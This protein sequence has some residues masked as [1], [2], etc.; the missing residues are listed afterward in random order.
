MR[1][2]VTCRRRIS[3]RCWRSSWAPAAS[4][5]GTTFASAARRA[6]TAE[7]LAQAGST[8]GFEVEVVPPVTLDGER[9]SSSGVR[10]ALAARGLRAR[11]ALARTALF[12]VRARGGGPAPGAGS[13]VPD[14]EPAAQAPARPGGRHFCGARARHCRRAARRGGEPRH[15]PHGGGTEALLEAHVFDFQGD[16]YGR[17]IEVEFVAK[18]RDEEHFAD[19]RRADRA[20]ACGMPPRRAAS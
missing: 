17:E 18:L 20:D 13:R 6:A 19:A 2:C 9:V 4:W 5:S 7:V 15:A 11:R 1:L 16:L 8:L 14:R 10:D 12:D 3:R